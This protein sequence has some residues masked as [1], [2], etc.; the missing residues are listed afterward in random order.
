MDDALFLALAIV[1]F[2][3]TVGLAYLFEGL[4]EHK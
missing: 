4:R 1:F 3:A 2:A